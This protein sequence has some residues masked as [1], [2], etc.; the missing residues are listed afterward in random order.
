[1]R[2]AIDENDFVAAKRFKLPVW[3]P[4]ILLDH[5]KLKES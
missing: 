2:G 4:V 5:L 1:V 3:T